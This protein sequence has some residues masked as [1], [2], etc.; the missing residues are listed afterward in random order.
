MEKDSGKFLFLAALIA[1][2]NRSREDR[3]AHIR[4]QVE[5]LP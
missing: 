5:R 2:E 1:E 4:K 3:A